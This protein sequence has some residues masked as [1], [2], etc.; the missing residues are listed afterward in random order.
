LLEQHRTEAAHLTLEVDAR[1]LQ[2][3]D[4]LASLAQELRPLSVQV[5]LQHF[6]RQ[7][8]LI[9]ELALIGLSYLKIESSFI[10]DLD[11]ESDK[12]L[13]LEALVRT[14]QRIDLLLI[15]EQVQSQSEVSALKQLGIEAMQGRALAEPGEW[16]D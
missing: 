7:L 14:A 13:Y 3:C 16:R 12:H 11:T 1:Y 8:S 5:G 15:A 6:G 2:G 9:G 4:D 10:R